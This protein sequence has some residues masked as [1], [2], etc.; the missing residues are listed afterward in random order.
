MT[1]TP[2]HSTKEKLA[3]V[4]SVLKD[5]KP[6][7]EVCQ[8]HQ[9]TPE[10]YRTYL[11]QLMTAGAPDN[12]VRQKLLILLQQQ[13]NYGTNATMAYPGSPAPKSM[14]QLMTEAVIKPAPEPEIALE[15]KDVDFETEEADFET[16]TKPAPKLKKFIIMGIVLA[17][18][19]GFIFS[20]VSAAQKRE[21]ITNCANSLK[22]LGLSALTFSNDHDD[23]FPSSMEQLKIY[24][25][26]AG[27]DDIIWLAQDVRV[28]DIGD[29]SS[30][31]IALCQ[32]DTATQILF[33]D[34]HVTSVSDALELSSYTFV[35]IPYGETT[36]YADSGLNGLDWVYIPATVNKIEDGAL[37]GVKRLYLSRHNT[38][39]VLDDKG[40][41]Q[42]RH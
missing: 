28:P 17:V 38:A 18:V 31:P 15:T 22:L 2:K 39:F 40:M 14:L 29:H 4:L 20:A 9:I 34:G 16:V 25:C 32:H 24:G 26:D 27:C 23:R 30:Y 35:V 33:A 6:L 36:I 41:L 3:I 13:Q 11:K 21:K 10:I 37:T 12:P 19:L 5:N 7:Q 42:E 8:E 1:N